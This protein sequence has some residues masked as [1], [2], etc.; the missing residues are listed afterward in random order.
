[1]ST[2]TLTETIS[3]TSNQLTGVSGS[4]TT[5]YGYD[6]KGNTTVVNG[7]TTYNYDGYNRLSSAAG[8]SYYVSPEGQRLKKSSASGTSYF[9]PDKGGGLLAE[10]QGSGWT[11]YIWLGGRL[12]GKM[13]SSQPYAIF[14]DQVGRP[15]VVADPSQA[16]VWRAQNFPFYQKVVTAKIPFN[17]GFPGQ[18]YDAETA[19]WN[20]GFRDYS[21]VYGR[22][23]E[24]DPL[25]VA[26]GINTYAYVGNNP[27]MYSDPLGLRTGI[28][29]WQPVGWGESSFGHVSTDINGTTYSWGPGGMAVLPTFDYLGKNSFRSGVENTIKLTPMHEQDLKNFLSGPQGKYSPITNNCASPI[30]RGLKS[31]GIDTGGQILPVSLGNKLLDMGVTS[32]SQ[33]FQAMSPATGTSAPWA[34]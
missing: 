19:T 15:E 10:T 11:D 16:V 29:V 26:A 7:A 1:M 23:I 13:T 8:M 32:G 31:L 33:E 25:G 14:V 12:I 18:Y 4:S 6:A 17:L 20:N 28:T 9:A 34:H 21:S 30:Q 27:L 5:N 3:S 24:S 2:V 22:N